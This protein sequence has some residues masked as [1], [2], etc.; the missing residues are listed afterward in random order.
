MVVVETPGSC[1]NGGTKDGLGRAERLVDGWR[2]KQTGEKIERL[3]A[4][5]KWNGW[6]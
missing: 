1:R 2:V 6:R 5:G 4:T 3:V